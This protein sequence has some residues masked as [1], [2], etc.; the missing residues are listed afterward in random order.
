MAAKMP[1]GAGG[2]RRGAH[3]QPAA[4]LLAYLSH[5]IDQ[6]ALG[7]DPPHQI[8]N[9]SFTFY[10]LQLISEY[11][12]SGAGGD[13]RGAHAQPGAW[14]YKVNSPTKSTTYCSLLLDKILS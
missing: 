13:R 12:V 10:F 8:D 1:A 4:G 2:D 11:I 6:T 9:L 5:S 7:S 3:A 14:F